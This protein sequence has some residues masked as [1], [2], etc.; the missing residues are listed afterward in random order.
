MKKA[1]RL[2]SFLVALTLVFGVITVHADDKGFSDVGEDNPY[3][4]YITMLSEQGIIKGY[5]D[6]QFAPKSSCTK[7][8]F[9]TFIY[10]AEGEPAVEKS[11]GFTDVSEDAYY[12]DAVS[13]AVSM[14][15]TN[16]AGDNTFGVGNEI[17]RNLAIQY[18]YK[19]AEIK[20]FLNVYQ[21]VYLKEFA[22]GDKAYGHPSEAF[23]WAVAE[24]IVKPDAE[25]KVYPNG[26]VTREWAAG[27]IG[28]ILEKHY[29]KWNEYKDNGDGTH[30]RVCALDA[31]HVEKG[32]HT[33]NNG[34]LIKKPTDTTDGEILYTCTKCK[35]QE[36]KKAEA[37]EEIVTRADAEEAA[38]AAAWAYYAKGKSMQYDATD[39]SNLSGYLGGFYRTSG[40]SAPE[41][42]TPDQ[43]FYSVCSDYVY[44]TYYEA[45][46]LKVLGD[47]NHPFGLTTTDLFRHAE[48]QIN[49]SNEK[50][51][52]NDFIT[53]KDVNA[54]VIKWTDF[55]KSDSHG[56]YS[57]AGVYHSDKFDDFTD[58]IVFR[59]D[60]PDGSYH[61]GYYDNDGNLIAP[62]KVFADYVVPFVK[63]EE[64]LR[65]GDVIVN[66]GHTMIYIGND[67]V[68]HCNGRKIDRKTA[69]DMAEE[70]GSILID[71]LDYALNCY[72]TKRA[73]FVIIRPLEFVTT[74]SFDNDP[75]NDI[76]TDKTIFD[77]TKSRVKYPVM[78]ID[79]TVDITQFG[80]VS[81]GEALTYNI[82]IA[83]KTSDE[84][85]INWSADK[86]SV[87]Y[88]DLKVTEEIPEGAELVPDSVTGGGVYENGIITWNLSEVKPGE[89]VN[90]SYKVKAIGEI[91]DVIVNDG[92][93]VDNIPSNVLRNTIGGGKLTEG[94][95]TALASIAT[96][97]KDAFSNYGTDTD[98]ADNIYKK[99]GKEIDLPKTSDIVNNLFTIKSHIPG[100][101]KEGGGFF[102]ANYTPI[103]LFVRQNEV[104]DEFKE[105]KSMVVDR[106]WGG[107]YFYAGDDLRQDYATK[108]INDFRTSYLE[109][110]DVIVY[111]KA[112]DAQKKA[113]TPDLKG[114][115]VMVFDGSNLL[116]MTETA[117]GADYAVVSGADVNA[118]LL[119][120]FKTD[121]DLFFALRPTQA[122]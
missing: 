26:I 56:Y 31:S 68:L 29:H 64:N 59:N 42:A 72:S 93:F 36:I 65:V 6:G 12:A 38:V 105:V 76:I 113:I 80:T 27:A 109:A 25:N 82:S 75:G 70:N 20:G 104:S 78:N 40:Q 18:L 45:M 54:A 74:P 57:C 66:T 35:Y 8:Q 19:W 99:I 60:A 22:D 77:S 73:R 87:T 48:N 108:V 90:L 88:K 43:N 117:D 58:E 17:D 15:M 98:F 41:V 61:Y 85:Y 67:R 69:V 92:G 47:V 115:T 83:N 10:R 50:S 30:E 116:C 111:V 5:G 24:G 37:G 71:D 91:G 13:W 44:Q 110:G 14:G 120:A 1:K 53:E 100:D 2:L 21:G 81:K 118:K 62:E 7:E 79:R 84:E 96:D 4:N 55:D 49:E 102:P 112:R 16:G 97:G 86:S 23:S 28:T 32:E 46:R 121:C 11:S 89:T 52:Y 106:Y 94:E 33:F 39:L 9:L 51:A 107:S 101:S 63:N 95:L 122:K 34:E 119:E 103:D 3:I 114:V